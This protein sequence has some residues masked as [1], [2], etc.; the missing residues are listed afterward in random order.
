MVECS[1]FEVLRALAKIGS[2]PELSPTV[3]VGETKQKAT[4]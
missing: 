4:Q 1:F 3:M 2:G